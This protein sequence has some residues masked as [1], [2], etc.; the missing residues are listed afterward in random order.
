MG[1]DVFDIQSACMDG[2]GRRRK[3]SSVALTEGE[4]APNKSESAVAQSQEGSV[5]VEQLESSSSTNQGETTEEASS[6]PTDPKKE[7]AKDD[8]DDDLLPLSRL[9]KRPRLSSPKK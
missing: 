1:L 9:S 4:V 5:N 7:K 6:H 8:E 3:R 2:G